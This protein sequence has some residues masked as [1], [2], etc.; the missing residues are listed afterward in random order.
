VYVS[1]VRRVHEYP[2]GV[3]VIYRQGNGRQLLARN[4]DCRM[5]TVKPISVNLGYLYSRTNFIKTSASVA[6]N[7]ERRR[8]VGSRVSA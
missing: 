7:V 2:V 3:I 8:D 1:T 5:P 4:K 6:G